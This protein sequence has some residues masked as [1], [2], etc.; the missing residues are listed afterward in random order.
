M[1]IYTSWVLQGAGIGY[2]A[3]QTMEKMA[4]DLA[5][6]R[7]GPSDSDVKI[8]MVLDTI[9][10]SFQFSEMHKRLFYE[11]RGLEVP[12]VS[13]SLAFDHD[14]TVYDALRWEHCRG[15]ETTILISDGSQISLQ[16]WYEKQGYVQFDEN[17]AGN[18]WTKGEI[19]MIVPLVYYQK[20]L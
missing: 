18:T 11:E 6:E 19:T 16:Q 10:A 15:Y 1:G 7:N 5:I 13:L 4:I 20:V 2:A 8:M 12:K 3:M 14:A 9:P 17:P